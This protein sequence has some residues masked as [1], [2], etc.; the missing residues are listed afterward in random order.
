[1]KRGSALLALANGEAGDAVATTLRVARQTVC[2]WLQ[3]F[4]LRRTGSFMARRAPGRPSKLTTTQ[5]QRLKALVAGG[6]LA[7]GYP[8]G[9][10]TALLIQ[11]LI[12]R[13]FGVLYNR[14]YVCALLC[15]LGFSFQKARFVSDHLD[16]E[17]RQRWRQEAWPT[18]LAEARQRGALLFFGDEASFPQWGS[19]SYTWALV[20][21]QPVGPPTGRRKAYNVF[22]VI[23]CF[24]GRLFYHGHAGRFTAESYQAFL[25]RVLS[26][27]E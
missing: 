17:R 3:E 2:T 12:R 22:G 1:M 9:C 6:P 24:P 4:L 18:I 14:H 7:A 21:H 20:G 13:E 19:L 11:D 25:T 16:E 10:W 15:N 26:S 23:D 27:S 5:Q 8:T